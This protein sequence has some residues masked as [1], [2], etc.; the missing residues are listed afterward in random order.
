[1]TTELANKEIQD[2]LYAELITLVYKQNVRAFVPLAITIALITYLLSRTIDT[3]CAL[4]W[5]AIAFLILLVRLVFLHWIENSDKWGFEN[6]LTWICILSIINGSMH[7]S[8]LIYFSVLPEVDRAILSM[9]LMAL[10][11]GAVGTSA[12]YQPMFWCYT[13]PVILSSAISWLLNIQSSIEQHYAI[14]IGICMLFLLATLASLSHHTFRYFK[15]S[16]IAISREKNLTQQLTTALEQAQQ[17]KA[18]AEASNQS[19]V[20]FLA[21]ASHDLRQPVHVLT[22]FSAA[23]QQQNLSEEAIKISDDMD[24]AI[25][26]LASQLHSLLDVSK[27]DAG[28][29]EP[30]LTSLSYS[31]LVETLVRESRYE[32][33]VAGLTIASVI[34]PDIKILSDSIMLTQIVRNLLTNAIKYTHRGSIT[35]KL[36]KQGEKI[37]LQIADTGVGIAEYDRGNV[38]EEFYQVGNTHRDASEGLGLGLSIVQRLCNL[39]DA[40]IELES[41]I[42]KG[43][44]VTVAHTVSDIA[45]SGLALASQSNPPTRNYGLKVHVIDD[46]KLIRQGTTSLLNSL[47]CD[48]TSASSTAESLAVVRADNPDIFLV[49]L[50][51]EGG[52]S[53]LYAIESL[54]PL[55]PDAQFIM[56][57]GDTNLERLGLEQRGV[58]TMQKPLKIDD[59]M[60]LLDDIK[61][62]QSQKTKAS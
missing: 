5:F 59:L 34:E 37:L 40:S 17:E 16:V 39:L 45:T 28:I 6:K 23:L 53:G 7:A 22:L 41:N 11:A 2:S 29:V 57:S 13:T 47:G 10:G 4:T 60:E 51:L 24:K 62:G 1:M 30:R 46:Q 36:Y 44:T 15:S 21:A 58:I 12:G 56:I 48:T 14:W 49:D 38:F 26:S 33:E 19:K 54:Q 50:R 31:G 43:T 42:G 9:I 61:A 25:S 52:D 3:A 8:S 18:K 55:F 20:R 27:L 35:V 32:A